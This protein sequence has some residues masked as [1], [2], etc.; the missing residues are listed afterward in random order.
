MS[1]PVI[2][3]TRDPSVV[4]LEFTA[5]RGHCGVTR[6]LLVYAAA[7]L[8]EIGGCFAVSA[9]LRLDRSAW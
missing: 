8:A 2:H 7:A 1:Q 9:W 4:V 3:E 5:T 6:T